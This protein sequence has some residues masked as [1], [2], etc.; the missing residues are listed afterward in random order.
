MDPMTKN[1]D[2]GMRSVQDDTDSTSWGGQDVF[3]VY[4]KSS[5][6]RWMGR[7]IRIGS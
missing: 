7:N 4:S 6:R 5:G 3:D 2:W 1:N